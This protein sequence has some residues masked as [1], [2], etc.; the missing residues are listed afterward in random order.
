MVGLK[1]K[2]KRRNR[3][4]EYTDLNVGRHTAW[5]N[6]DFTFALTQATH[7]KYRDRSFEQTLLHISFH[8]STKSHIAADNNH[9]RFAVFNR[10]CQQRYLVSRTVLTFVTVFVKHIQGYYVITVTSKEQ[11]MFKIQLF[12]SPSYFN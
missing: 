9:K 2:G 3:S 4:R 5:L 1:I 7:A 10:F 6:S 12:E 11:T 8:V